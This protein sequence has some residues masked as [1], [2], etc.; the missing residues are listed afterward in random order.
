MTVTVTIPDEAVAAFNRYL[1][2]QVSVSMDE[3]THV[4][5]TT[6]HYDGI[7]GFVQSKIAD[8]VTYVVADFSS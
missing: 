5:T 7:A 2:T 1:E 4:V 8:V 3:T 6:P